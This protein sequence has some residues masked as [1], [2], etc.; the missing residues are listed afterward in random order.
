MT[1]TCPCCG[2]LSDS[3]PPFF[4]DE[5][6]NAVRVDGKT[7][8]LSPLQTKLAAVM[9]K[10]YPHTAT[11]VGIIELMYGDDPNGGPEYA[12][13]IIGIYVHAI[14]RKIKGTSLSIENIWG[15][16]YKFV[17]ESGGKDV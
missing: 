7:L 8:T 12:E 1:N 13:S 10:K 9:A 2:Q 14:R 5:D 11:K 4:V 3:A 16:G 6:N 15:V 17:H